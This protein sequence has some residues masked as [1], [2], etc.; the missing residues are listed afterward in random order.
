MHIRRSN[1]FEDHDQNLKKGKLQT[2]L[3]SSGK[4]FCFVEVLT[5]F[6]FELEKRKS[7]TYDEKQ[8]LHVKLALWKAKS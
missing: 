1:N 4:T 7:L 5:N 8:Y 2:I 3:R 6:W